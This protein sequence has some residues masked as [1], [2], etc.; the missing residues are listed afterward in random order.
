MYKRCEEQNIVLNDDKRDIGKEIIFHGHR[1]NPGT[2]YFSVDSRECN[3]LND[4]D[5][6]TILE[7]V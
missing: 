2:A 5:A 6:T 4:F 1:M 3:L 7:A